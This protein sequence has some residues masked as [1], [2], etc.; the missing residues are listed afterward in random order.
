MKNFITQMQHQHEKNLQLASLAKDLVLF[1][2]LRADRGLSTTQILARM[3]AR[4]MGW[5]ILP[6]SLKLFVRNFRMIRIYGWDKGIAENYP[7]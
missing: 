3:M 7:P 1:T 5:N 4:M 6:W 2:K